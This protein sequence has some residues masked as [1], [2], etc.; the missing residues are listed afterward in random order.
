MKVQFK[1]IKM[2]IFSLI[3]RTYRAGKELKKRIGDIVPLSG[4]LKEIRIS[5]IHVISI[6]QGGWMYAVLLSM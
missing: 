2:I 6:V 5:T 4:F 3:S 1:K